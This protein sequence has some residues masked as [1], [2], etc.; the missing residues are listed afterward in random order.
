MSTPEE[1]VKEAQKVCDVM[2]AAAPGAVAAAKKLVA[3]VQYKP[4]T[5]ELQAYTA[6]QCA[7]ARP[8]RARAPS[9]LALM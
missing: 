7:R 2:L 6:D 3:G 1:L 5:P 9:S 8:P 4:V